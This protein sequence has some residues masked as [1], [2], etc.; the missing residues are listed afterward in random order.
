MG[1][2]SLDAYADVAGGDVIAGLRRL[3]APLKSLRVLHINAT[4]YGGGVSELLRSLVPLENDLGLKSEWRIVPGKN[5]FFRV[6]RMIHDA[7][8]G[9]AHSVLTEIDKETY[10][11]SNYTNARAIKPDDYDIV[12]IHDPQPAAILSA[13]GDGGGPKWIWRCHIDTSQPDQE[14][15]RYFRTF[16][17]GYHKAVFTLPEFVP[18]DFPPIDV[19]TM[20]PAIDP[21][22]PKNLALTPDFASRILAWLGMFAG[23]PFITQVS[24]FD[25]WKDPFGVI[26]AYRLVREQ[27][28]DIHLALVGSMA[29][30]DPAAWE[31]HARL[32]EEDAKEPNLH[33]F[34]NLTGVSNIEVNAFQQ[35]A[36]VVIQKSI[37][38]GFGLVV[39][40]ALWKGTPVVAGR[41]GGIP[42]QLSAG[43]G[44][45]VDTTEECAARVIELLRS[46]D[47]AARMGEAGKRSVTERFLV[48]RLLEQQLALFQSVT[49]LSAG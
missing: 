43:G 35:L 8:Q 22:S 24:R 4:P 37:R 20:P 27:E 49:G 16:L 13:L 41:A 23:E 44:Y 9:D 39:S 21:L 29:L 28:P 47:R 18:P 14:T 7:L 45:L 32:A 46:P 42:L 11:A 48:T 5:N 34:T 31:I 12:M 38:E 40:E 30:D 10:L 26:D 6:T 17:T 1:R 2:H 19:V 3:A 33:I 15:W 25:K 36:K